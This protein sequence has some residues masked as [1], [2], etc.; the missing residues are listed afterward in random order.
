MNHFAIVGNLL[1]AIAEKPQETPAAWIGDRSFLPIFPTKSLPG[2]VVEFHTD[3]YLKGWSQ[4]QMDFFV[5][6]EYPM[7][8]PQDQKKHKSHSIGQFY[9]D[10]KAALIFLANNN[11]IKFDPEAPF[12]SS[13]TIGKIDSLET[14][15]NMIERI[16]DEGEGYWKGSFV[17]PDPTYPKSHFVKFKEMQLLLRYDEQKERYVV[18]LKEPYPFSDKSFNLKD[19]S[20]CQEQKNFKNA[21]R[22]LME[23]LQECYNSGADIPMK[24]M[25]LLTKAAVPLMNKGVRPIFSIE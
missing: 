19:D 1:S 4:E 13:N 22:G 21:L 10:L 18:P 6:I 12:I 23:A 20:K 8:D 3:L 2:G 25:F 7:W 15:K 16:T 17:H 9:S 24:E 14:A 5:T 11:K